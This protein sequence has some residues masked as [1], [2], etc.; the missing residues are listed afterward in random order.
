MYNSGASA[1]WY[2]LTG[3]QS[4]NISRG[5]QRFQDPVNQSSLQVE[6]IPATS[7][8]L[9][10]AVGQPIEVRV[11]TGG[12]SNCYFQGRITDI[13]RSYA[14]PYNSGTNY[15]P[16]DRITISATGG[17]GVLGTYLLSGYPLNADAVFTSIGYICINNGMN[18]IYAAPSNGVLNSGNTVTAGA[19]DT[20]NQLLRTGQVTLDDIA[21]QRTNPQ[22][23]GVTIYPTGVILNSSISFTDTG[24]GYAYTGLE[25]LSSVQNTFNWVSVQATGL[26]AAVTS[27]TAPFNSLNYTTY[28]ASTSDATSLSNYVYSITSGQFSA[29]PYSISTNTMSAPNCMALAL[30][31]QD[32]PRDTTQT[33]MGQP[34][35]V[36]FRG[37][38]SNA[39]VIG[40]NSAFYP[41]H[42]AVQ[43][44][45]SPSLGTPFTLDSSA[46]GV[47]DTNRLGY[48]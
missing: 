18:C 42:A 20:I 19:L 14:F 17:T 23:S 35:S 32:Y 21:M 44:Y 12:S 34:V 48:P 10:L 4:V 11:D 37:S 24:S 28:N 41:D 3:V 5:R 40:V 38:T 29:V 9:D 16:G 13:Q 46:F 15:A 1:T 39:T 7:Y 8:S 36:T 6:L 22:V 26:A 33:V 31:L 47:L 2:T 25:F 27:G 30:I 43:L 45:L